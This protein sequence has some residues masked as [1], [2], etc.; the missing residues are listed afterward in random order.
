[1]KTSRTYTEPA[2]INEPER[3]YTGFGGAYVGAHRIAIVTGKCGPPTL[4]SLDHSS[5]DASIYEGACK[6]LA[7]YCDDEGLCI[8]G[9]YT[10]LAT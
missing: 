6:E 10:S 4:F 5:I 7:R 2:F 9:F 1:M 3:K 8:I